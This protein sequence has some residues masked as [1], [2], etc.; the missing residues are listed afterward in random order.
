MLPVYLV[1][2][3]RPEWVTSAAATF[4]GCDVRVL[5]NGGAEP[6][7]PFV[8]MPG[9]TGYTGGANHALREW[10]AGDDPFV[11]V[12]AHDCHAEPGAV[13][14]LLDVAARRT[15]YGVLTFETGPETGKGEQ[16]LSRDDTV[17][18]WEWVSG[19]A[20]LL[21][22]EAVEQVGLLDP[23]FLSYVED[24]DYCCRMRD[25]G[26]R[27]GV[28]LGAHAH[29]LGSSDLAVAERNI[30]ANWLLLLFKRREWLLLA[31][32]LRYL[33]ARTRRRDR[34]AALGL[35][36]GVARI[37]LAPFRR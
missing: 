4:S 9:N 11:L 32:W 20:L 12:C 27:V 18:E 6:A 14:R 16:V 34:A 30:A 31:R 21:R 33:V 7:I 17:E 35:P 15:D 13:A 1:H 36:L 22:R 29:G 37:A 5:H 3:D 23:A 19:T 10:L 8:R 26:W 2:Y 25:A 28:V 24:V